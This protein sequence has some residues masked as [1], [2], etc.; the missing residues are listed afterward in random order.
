MPPYPPPPPPAQ[1]WPP[2]H[3]SQ[4]WPPQPHP[5]AYGPWG[6]FPR[7]QNGVGTAGFVVSLIGLVF[8]MPT[9]L[10]FLSIP[11]LVVGLP[12]AGVGLQKA[13]QGHATNRGLAIAGVTCG[14]VGLVWQLGA[15]LL[16]A[17][18]KAAG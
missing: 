9:L 1:P 4:P 12:L 7:P 6:Y 15:F 10:P 3:Q 16:G 11:L 18:L 8:A 2:R 13:N 17:I 5:P 14:T